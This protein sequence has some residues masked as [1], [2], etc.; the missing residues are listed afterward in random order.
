MAT[1]QVTLPTLANIH[2]PA[3]TCALHHK[4]NNKTKPLG[5]LSRIE[6]LAL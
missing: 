2:S 6:A 3:L 1:V 5:S 4:L